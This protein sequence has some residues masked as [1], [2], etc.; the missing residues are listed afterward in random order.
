MGEALNV[1]LYG[2]PGSG[3]TW[4]AN[5]LLS[6]WAEESGNAS[7]SSQ[8]SSDGVG[9]S[10]ITLDG[11]VQWAMEGGAGPDLATAVKNELFP[12]KTEAELAAEEEAAKKAAAAAKSPPKGKKG[13]VLEPVKPP[14]PK[15]RISVG[16]LAEVL[17]QRVKRA[18]CSRGVILD[19]LTCSFLDSHG[20]AA[21]AVAAAWDGRR[22]PG[23]GVLQ[24]FVVSLDASA[25]EKRYEAVLSAVADTFAAVAQ[26]A[27]EEEAAIAAVSGAAAGAGTTWLCLLTKL[28]V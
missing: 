13:A 1:V 10:I 16:T 9:A 15:P 20:D 28:C 19:D 11:A 17:A 3:K 8:D 23:A 6:K 26:E 22:R 27:K 24:V 2:P 14:P 5:L 12:P 25:L 4:Q 21:A 18:D 7:S